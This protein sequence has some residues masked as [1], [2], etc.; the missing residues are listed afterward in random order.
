MASAPRAGSR[1]SRL[2]GSLTGAEWRRAGALAAALI[3]LHVFVVPEHFA[4]GTTGVFGVGVGVTAYTLGLRH[5]FDA[6]HIS[7]IDNTTRKLMSEGQR[8]LSVGFF[9]SLG[10]STVVF[11]LGVLVV[12]GVRGL[13]GAVHDDGS[14]LHQATGQP[15][16]PAPS[17]PHRRPQLLILVEVVRV[18]RRM[19]AAGSTRPH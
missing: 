2:R 4:L 8:P 18:F 13:S 16:S 7:A 14:L 5:A 6:D 12:I 17:C 19:R 11:A 15:T 3:G 1:R 9:F 10:H